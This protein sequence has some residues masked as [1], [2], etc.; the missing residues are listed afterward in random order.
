MWAYEAFECG[1]YT[2]LRIFNLKLKSMLNEGEYMVADRLYS[3]S[4]A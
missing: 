4:K 1:T 2:D 3:V